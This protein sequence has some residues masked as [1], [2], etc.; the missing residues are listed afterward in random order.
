[1]CIVVDKKAT[2]EIKKD[3]RKF[4][5]AYKTVYTTQGISFKGYQENKK[6]YWKDLLSYHSRLKSDKQFKAE[7]GYLPMIHNFL[8]KQDAIC[9]TGGPIL[10]VKIKIKDIEAVGYQDIGLNHKM[11]VVASYIKTL[12]RIKR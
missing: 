7:I 9:W 5:Y 1:M 2:E 8:S 10:K 4:L 11:S 6:Y 3:K 12:N